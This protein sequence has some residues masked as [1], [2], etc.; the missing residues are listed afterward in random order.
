MTPRQFIEHRPTETLTG[1]GLA[2]SIYG[3]L[4]QA[5]VSEALAALVAVAI[6]FVPAGL[7]EVV[8]AIRRR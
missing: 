3:F 7:S 1:L 8:D 2:A 4:T 6:A 5:G